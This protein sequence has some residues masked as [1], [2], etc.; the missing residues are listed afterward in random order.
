MNLE[1]LKVLA[2]FDWTAKLKTKTIHDFREKTILETLEDFL[3]NR[4]FYLFLY[5][6]KK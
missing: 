4:H 6:S 1:N 5:E 2:D 3:K